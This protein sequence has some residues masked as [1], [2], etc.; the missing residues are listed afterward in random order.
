M[1]CSRVTS[2]FSDH[3]DEEL[4]PAEQAVFNEH[5]AGC[6]GCRRQWEL[7]RA[8]VRR[9]QALEPLAPPLGILSGVQ[10][11]L[12]AGPALSWHGRLLARW[13]RFD[14]SVSLPTAVATVALAMIMA[15]LAREEVF[16]QYRGPAAQPAAVAAKPLPPAETFRLPLPETTLAINGRERSERSY[17][18][19][20][21]IPTHPPAIRVPVLER[22][23]V[24]MVLHAAPPEM[25][26]H[27]F[28]ETAAYQTW[29]VDYPERGLLLVE[30]PPA[31]LAALRE[32]LAPYP[33][34]VAP[35]AALSPHFAQ[36][37]NKLRVAIRSR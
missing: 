20:D 6:S 12:A 33:V 5:L 26:P 10:A 31:D 34:A 3:L 32:M 14:F 37:K 27:L 22:P 13:R 19:F 35:V 29:R 11:R 24:L 15:M 21:T 16:F 1:D 8:T 2:L 18:L 30:L 28:R 23:D 25:L 7:F 36:G 9:V 17:Q 4:A